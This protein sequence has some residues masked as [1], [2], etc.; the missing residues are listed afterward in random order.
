MSG[1]LR[2][3][4]YRDAE[5]HQKLLIGLQNTDSGSGTFQEFIKAGPYGKLNRINSVDIFRGFA[6]FFM[7][8]GKF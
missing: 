3:D 6:I 5:E 8:L 2:F 4:Q 7:I 1:F